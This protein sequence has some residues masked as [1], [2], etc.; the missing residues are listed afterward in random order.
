MEITEIFK[1]LADSTRVRMVN[2]LIK[3]GILCIC[4]IEYILGISQVNASRH[5]AKLKQSKIVK[6]EKRA[7]WVYYSINCDIAEKYPFILTAFEKESDEEMIKNDMQKLE[8]HIKNKMSCKGE[9]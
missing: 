4:D 9:K 8:E 5:L 2:L 3:G 7:Q 1:G 6:A